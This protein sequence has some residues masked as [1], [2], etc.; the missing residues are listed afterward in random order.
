MGLDSEDFFV[1]EVA[2]S[3]LPLG[4]VALCLQL[5]SRARGRGSNRARVA[6]DPIHLTC[7]VAIT[8]TQ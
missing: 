4:G 1:K 8:V 6:G 3:T 5:Q 7:H 2:T